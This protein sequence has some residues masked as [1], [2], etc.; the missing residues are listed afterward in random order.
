M[1]RKSIIFATGNKDKLRETQSI[2]DMPVE[3]TSLEVDEI[4]SLDPIKV[5]VAKARAYYKELK[6]PI[7]VEDSSASFKAIEPLPGP[8]LKDFYYALGGERLC[9]LLDGKSRDVIVKVIIVFINEKGREYIFESDVYGEIAEKPRGDKG[10]GWDPVFIPRG[11][12][13]TFG[14]MTEKEK[15]KYSMRKIALLKFKGWLET[16]GEW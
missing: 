16:Q 12:D 9:R 11:S 13:K 14:E 10:W 5:A 2:L 15:S 7:F 1:K 6:K 3:G 4:Q 8:Y